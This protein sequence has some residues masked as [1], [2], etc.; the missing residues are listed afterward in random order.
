MFHGLSMDYPIIVG[1][2]HHASPICHEIPHE[3]DDLSGLSHSRTPLKFQKKSHDQRLVQVC[4]HLFPLLSLLV[5][6]LL[7]RGMWGFSKMGTPIAGR[8]IMENPT[9]IWM[10]TGGTPIFGNHHITKRWK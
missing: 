5:F 4:G 2:I 3:F 6:E 8:F 9:K 10:I 1:E 7:C